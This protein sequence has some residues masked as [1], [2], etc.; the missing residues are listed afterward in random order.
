VQDN[1]TNNAVLY[2]IYLNKISVMMH[3]V[4]FYY[5]QYQLVTI[6]SPR[7]W[8][9]INNLTIHKVIRKRNRIWH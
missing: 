1:N 8:Y 4:N 9:L 5:T 3:Y 7:S 6:D 2:W